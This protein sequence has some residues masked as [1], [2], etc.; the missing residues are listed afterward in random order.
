MTMIDYGVLDLGGG[1]GVVIEG[2]LEHHRLTWADGMCRAILPPMPID[3][4]ITI[5]ALLTSELR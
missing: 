3:T 2:H 5:A 4:A 1:C